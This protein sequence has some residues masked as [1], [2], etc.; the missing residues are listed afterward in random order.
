MELDDL[1]RYFDA[2][3]IPTGIGRVQLEIIPRLLAAY[4]ARVG[5]CRIGS[6][7]DD[8]RIIEPERLAELLGGAGKNGRRRP[9]VGGWV[10]VLTRYLRRRTVARFDQWAA[11]LFRRN[12]FRDAVREGDVLLALGGSW[13]HTHFG[14]SIR[15]LKERHGIKFALLI[16]DILPVTHPQFVSAG[17]L[18]NFQRWLKDMAASWDMVLTPSKSS[19]EAL[20][21]YL[22][23][24][25]APIP[26]ITPVPFGFG[27]GGHTDT[28]PASEAIEAEPY[29]MFVS[30]IEIRKNH[31][32][33][34]R[35]WEQLLRRHDPAN[36]PKL[37]FVGSQGWGVD[38]LKRR[39]ASSGNLGGR[40]R[41]VSDLSDAE[42]ARAYADCLFTVFPSFCE[43]WGLPVSESL[44]HGRL[45]LASNATSVPEIGGDA[46][47]YFDPEDEAGALAAVERALFEPGYVKRREAWIREN[48][49]LPAWESTARAVFEAI[50]GD[51]QG[52]PS[53]WVVGR[54]VA[55]NTV[56][57]AGDLAALP[58]DDLPVA[59]PTP[60]R[61]G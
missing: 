42:M 61:T 39:L 31:I 52:A 2:H 23:A 32:L 26:P 25:G 21:H 16:H 1:L 60:G 49:R 3:S 36:V 53:R 30:T 57:R 8:V 34:Y 5:I 4:P 38:L 43:G 45:C 35:V 18:P 56:G 50:V 14:R 6:T 15:A 44:F 19:A 59:W 24:G 40:V 7:P 22:G 33:M 54:A 13:T 12:A 27:F 51:E 29:V 37:L 10:K 46:V 11:R 58:A 55:T 48:F 20:R 17:H 28:A 9:G 47:D 41:H